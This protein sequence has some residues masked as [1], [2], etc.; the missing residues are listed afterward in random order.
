MKYFLHLKND[1]V[2]C[3][4]VWVRFLQTVVDGRCAISK[5]TPAINDET[6]ILGVSWLVIYF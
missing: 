2:A 5:Y 6:M 3:L 1:R 4:V